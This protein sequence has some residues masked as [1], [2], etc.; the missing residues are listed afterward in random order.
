[1]AR[2][3]LGR[4]QAAHAGRLVV[5]PV[6]WE[7]QPLLASDSFQAQ[8]A[9]PSETDVVVAVL[10]SRLGTPLPR[11]IR[12]A[13]GSAYRS[14]TEFE[15]EDALA[16]ARAHGRPKVL[17]YRKTA[18]PGRWFAS[19]A[20]A[21][22]AAAQRDALDAF[23]GGLLRD[24]DDG[25]FVAAFHPFTDT[26]HF[27]ELLE[28]HLLRLL[29]ELAP[30][31]L[32]E[33]DEAPV[34]AWTFGSPFR[35]LRSFGIEHAAVFFGRTRATAEAVARLQEQA[36][37]GRAFLLL[38]GMSGGG[39]SSLAKA[40]VLPMLMQPGVVEGVDEWRYAVFKPGEAGG[41][42][43]LALCG[44]LASPHALPSLGTAAELA[45]ELRTAPELVVALVTN[46]LD[47]AGPGARLALVVDQLEEAFTDAG[48]DRHRF[49]DLIDALARSGRVW[50]VA[51]LRSDFYSRCAEL[52][53]LLELKSG[54]GQ[55]DVLPPTPSEMAQMIRLPAQAAGLRY[56]QRADTGER[57]DERLRDV[58]CERPGT[59]PL[60][61]FTL[62]ELYRRRRGD[63]LLTF[64]AY[65][66][67][68]GLE[69]AL[70]HRAES[71]FAE[72][73]EAVQA[74]LPR[75]FERLVTL[76]E[77]DAIARR[78]A[79]LEG[80]VDDDARRLVEVLVDA[81]LLV[82]ELDESGATYVDVAHEALFK[83]WPRL[84]SW[85]LDNRELLRIRSRV[86]AAAE[87]WQREQRQPEFLLASGKPHDEAQ[88]LMAA[89]VPLEPL[90]AEFVAAST[91][92]VK[93][94]RALRRGAIAAL[95]G[96]ALAATVAAVVAVN[97]AE[98]ARREATTAS[99]TS[100]FMTSLFAV[101]DPGESRG[102]AVTARELLDRGATQINDELRGEPL[103][104][105]ELMHTMGVAYSGLGLNDP[106]LK[107]TAEALQE[108]KRQL[109]RNHPATLASQI[110]HAYVL[111]QSADYPAAAAAYQEAREVAA[112]LY[113]RGDLQRTRAT[114]GLAELLTFTGHPDEAERLYREALRELEQ[115]PGDVSRE[116]VYASGGLATALLF[117][118]R[119]AD[120]ETVYLE[121]LELGESALGG[122]H[123]KVAE[124]VNNLGSIAYQRGHYA[125]ARA[126]WER[127]LPI[128]RSIFGAEH[129]E[130]ATVLNNLG[131][132][133][134]I[135]R[136]FDDAKQIL[137]GVVQMDRRLKGATH[138][139]LAL[140]LNSLALAL[141]GRGE[142]AA[143]EA[144]YKEALEIAEHHGHWMRGVIRTNLADLHLRQGALEAAAREI[145]AARVALEVD[146][147]PDTRGDEGWRFLLL[148]SVEGA[149]LA[150][151][152]DYA[153]A[154]PR[155]LG[156]IDPLAERFG[157]RSLFA[158][159]AMRRAVDYYYAKS[160]DRE[161]AAALRRRL[162]RAQAA[163]S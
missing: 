135:E 151:R 52:P 71:V 95:A 119:L 61:Q 42:L 96:L 19:D 149:M 9:R 48:A 108:R 126:Y 123:P 105:A 63:G 7:Q 102:N 159:D 81:R 37:R 125:R 11:Q 120:A 109:G 82:S 132:V 131:R 148:D 26:A 147:P 44:A 142:W 139:D 137:S 6:L 115:L 3:V 4:L 72:Q 106:A 50:V 49:V 91:A 88:A 41:D 86:T 161:G 103:V 40:G 156:G 99:R 24:A 27:E 136:R 2:R 17:L 18:P 30:D 67:I 158:V 114:M 143:A 154:R 34:A 152:G 138:D 94:S 85:L 155:L 90:E 53:A 25:S 68:G 111:F 55:Y 51:T 59:L 43:I 46:A 1:M 141:A 23:L 22:E 16:G 66:D 5:E 12:R 15:I 28:L 128:H 144:S 157:E 112:E 35:G 113:P 98:K 104:R 54:A 10:W 127:T 83:H 33:A 69:G 47:A 110:A 97:Q 14:G 79:T 58:S 133:A 162:Q 146:F 84:A 87:L 31:A 124:T 56:E 153:A 29:P 73:P 160:G 107:L 122:N 78:R 60:L 121:T 89:A 75:V 45:R 62:E 93:R 13:D 101:A 39:K 116:R 117:Q 80:Y 21:L 64:A 32:A 76:A 70:A 65:A 74:A 36:H 77:D 20:D 57:L 145:G 92:R 130:I 129:V 38:L 134:L 8:L 100:E 150:M 163:P 140:S 118:S